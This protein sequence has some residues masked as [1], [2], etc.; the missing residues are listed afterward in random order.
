MISHGQKNRSKLL[1]NGLVST[2]N[3]FKTYVAAQKVIHQ[4]LAGI[5]R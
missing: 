5:E 2:K 3:W 4:P 1:E